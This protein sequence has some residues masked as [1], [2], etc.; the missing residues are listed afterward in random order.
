MKA[1][2]SQ[3]ESLALATYVQQMPRQGWQTV[4][5]RLA[6]KSLFEELTKL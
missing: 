3:V 4:L 2:Q 1:R 6:C 5:H